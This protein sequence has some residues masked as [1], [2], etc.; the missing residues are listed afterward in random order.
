MVH[1]STFE[2]TRKRYKQVQVEKFKESEKEQKKINRSE[3]LESEP[4][5]TESRGQLLKQQTVKEAKKNR[6]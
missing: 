2:V 3:D 1:K 4:L 5:P 6:T